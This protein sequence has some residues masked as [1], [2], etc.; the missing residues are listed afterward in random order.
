MSKSVTGNVQKKKT[1]SG[2]RYYPYINAKTDGRSKP[3]YLGCSFAAKKE[4]LRKLNEEIMLRNNRPDN[5]EHDG[6]VLFSDWVAGW[7]AEKEAQNKIKST[8]LR[9]YRMI[10][11]AHVIPYFAERK[12]KLSEVGWQELEKYMQEKAKTLC[13]GSLKCHRVVLSQALSYARKHKLI[14]VSPMQDMELPESRK[15][16]ATSKFVPNAEQFKEILAALENEE[17]YPLIFL[18]A[19]LGLR[20]GDAY[21]KHKLKIFADI[22]LRPYDRRKARRPMASALFSYD[23]IQPISNSAT[24]GQPPYLSVPASRAMHSTPISSSSPRKLCTSKTFR[25]I[26]A[27]SETIT[28]LTAPCRI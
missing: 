17:L 9:G 24:P 25:A 14:L 27:M 18:T 5:S 10:A 4:A 3:E 22:F 23:I 11:R 26:L 13:T 20:R 21:V 7:L 6:N 2:V 16:S 1:K 19:S 8:S 12:T 15:K 28:R